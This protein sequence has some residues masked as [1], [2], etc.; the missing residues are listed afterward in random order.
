[1]KVFLRVV[2]VTVSLVLGSQYETA[3]WVIPGLYGADVPCAAIG[4]K[5]KARP[6]RRVDLMIFI[7]IAVPI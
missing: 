1:M 2:T 4:I 5:P 7:F 3:S 6:M